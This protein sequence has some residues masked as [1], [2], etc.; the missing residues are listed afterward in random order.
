[1]RPICRRSTSCLLITV[2]FERRLAMGTDAPMIVEIV[3][4][5][6]RILLEVIR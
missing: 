4:V 3:I 1:M 2:P 5:V 6:L